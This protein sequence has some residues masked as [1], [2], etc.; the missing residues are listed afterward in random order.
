MTP[1]CANTCGTTFKMCVSLLQHLFCK[2]MLTINSHNNK[3]YTQA[4]LVQGKVNR[5]TSI[6]IAITHCSFKH[7]EACLCYVDACYY[8]L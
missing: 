2:I 1:V 8:T 5:I 3:L 6:S 7:C 4:H